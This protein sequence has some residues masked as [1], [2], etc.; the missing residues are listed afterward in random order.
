MNSI[1]YY[2]SSFASDWFYA[3]GHTLVLIGY[4][5]VHCQSK[6]IQQWV[7]SDE[8]AV[9]LTESF[10]YKL[11]MFGVPINNASNIFLQQ[12]GSVQKHHHGARVN[13]KEKATF[14]RS[15]SLL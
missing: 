8:N 10:W 11:R 3:N 1:F 12:R 14:N 9:E 15:L 13:P 6:Y 2:V 4:F 7:S 5:S